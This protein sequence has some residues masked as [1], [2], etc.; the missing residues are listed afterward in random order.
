MDKEDFV[1]EDEYRGTI[2]PDRW[3]QVRFIDKKEIKEGW[4]TTLE[5]TTT[6][7]TSTRKFSY[8]MS[9]DPLKDILDRITTMCDEVGIYAG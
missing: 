7:E 8:S 2:M 3:V 5:L 6:Y 4:V 1:I 9:E